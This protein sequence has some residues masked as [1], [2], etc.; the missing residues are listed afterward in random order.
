MQDLFTD[1]QIESMFKEDPLLLYELILKGVLT[2]IYTA[3]RDDSKEEIDKYAS[4]LI[5]KYAIH[6]ASFYHL[7][8]GIIEHRKSGEQIR[9]N[10]Y[11]LFSVN[12]VFR[13]I[14]E[15]YTTFNHIFIYPKSEDEKIFRYLLWKIDGLAEKSKFEI[16]ESI[17]DEVKHILEEDKNTLSNL[18]SEFENC[19]FCKSLAEQDL[20]RIYKSDKK[21]YNWR[22]LFRDNKVKPLSITNLVATVFPTSGY[23]NAYKYTSIHTHS[24]FYAIMEFKRIRGQLLTTEFTDPWVRLAI[25]ITCLLI[26]DLSTINNKANLTLGCMP[27]SIY[28]FI[29]GIAN[30]IGKKRYEN[31]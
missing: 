6:S 11:D 16:E 26:S 19:N 24:N 15:T 12:V 31:I 10:G 7:S 25:M 5:D 21:K 20:Y 28:R 14:M 30:S 9:M 27:S 13:A 29:V 1:S 8:S 22:F 18:I 4:L 17:L 23:I 2:P 3:Y